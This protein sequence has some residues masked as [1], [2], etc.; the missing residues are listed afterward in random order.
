M[1][2]PFYGRFWN[3]VGDP[4]EAS[5]GMWRLAKSNELGEFDGGYVSW[6]DI[7]GS[8]W[9]LKQ[10]VFHDKAKAPYVWNPANQTF[11]GY[12]NQESIKEKVRYNSKCLANSG[13]CMRRHRCMRMRSHSGLRMQ[14]YCGM[15]G[16]S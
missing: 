5:D 16:M 9:D 12:E 4:V 1:G 10:A 6:R 11:L 7:P 2:V 3:R 14:H 8:G 13:L 15:H